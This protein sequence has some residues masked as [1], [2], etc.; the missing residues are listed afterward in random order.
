MPYILKNQEAVRV[1]DDDAFSEWYQ[2][3][4]LCIKETVLDSHEYGG[5]FFAPYPSVNEGFLFYTN[6]RR[7]GKNTPLSDRPKYNSYQQ[8]IEGHKRVVEQIMKHS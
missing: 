3:A 1:A 2:S 7:N 8:A 4:N 5:T 6:I